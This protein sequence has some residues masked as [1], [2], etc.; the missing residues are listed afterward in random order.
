MDQSFLG[1]SQDILGW[2]G[3]SVTVQNP[4][5]LPQHGPLL[6]V[7]NHRSFLLASFLKQID[8]LAQKFEERFNPNNH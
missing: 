3:M 4:E 7:S 8:G 1:L 2:L 5:R 6:I